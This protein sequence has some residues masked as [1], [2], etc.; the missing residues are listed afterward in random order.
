VVKE[1]MKK[2]GLCINDA[3]DINKWRQC[4]RK[5]VDPS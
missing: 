1:N 2:R 4:C 3:K 5:V